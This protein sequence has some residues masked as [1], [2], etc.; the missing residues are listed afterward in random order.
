MN[1][2]L[3]FRV[4]QLD[5][6]KEG[7][8]PLL[9]LAWAAAK[10]RFNRSLYRCVF[11]GDLPSGDEKGSLDT[12]FFLLNASRPDGYTGRSLSV[13]DLV[14]FPDSGRTYY[15]DDYGWADTG[16]TAER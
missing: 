13:S 1:K 14:E 6:A 16:T 9:F 5:T 11:E 10:G 4:H 8:R 12:I 7:A 2:P 3:R 15:C